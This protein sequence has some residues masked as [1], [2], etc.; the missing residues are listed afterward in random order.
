[1]SIMALQRYAFTTPTRKDTSIG[2]FGVV[3]VENGYVGPH[4]CI[5]TT[6][7]RVDEAVAT[8]RTGMGY[9]GNTAAEEENT[10][11]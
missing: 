3:A 6:P 7:H 11:L 4:W 10:M 9:A 8:P 1:M 2:S 5:A